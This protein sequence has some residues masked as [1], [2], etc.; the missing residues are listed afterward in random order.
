MGALLDHFY[1]VGVGASVM[2]GLLLTVI[3]VRQKRADK[4]PNRMMAVLVLVLMFSVMLNSFLSSFLP[5]AYPNLLAFP[6]P[7]L[8]L[9]GPLFYYFIQSL[10]GS[11]VFKKTALLH[12]LPFLLVG[13]LFVFSVQNSQPTVGLSFRMGLLI[14]VLWL[15]IYLQFWGYYFLNRKALRGY[16]EKLKQSQSSIEKVRQAWITYCLTTLLICYSILG[17][18]FFL[19]HHEVFLP[20]NKILTVVLALILYSVGYRTFSRPE[21][22]ATLPVIRPEK[23][24]ILV[25][26]LAGEKYQKSGLSE[27]KALTQ[28]ETVE[29]LMK[30]EQSYL[31]PELDLKGLAGRLDFSPHHMS[32]II[33]N[34][35]QRNFYDFVNHYRLEAVKALLRNPDHDHR[36]VLTLAFETG[37]NSKATFN[38]FFKKATRQ[39]P[40]QFR[41]RVR[42]QDR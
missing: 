33:N 31:D 40:S 2:L 28:F 3:V 34:G 37:F 17:I 22:F 20:I 24:E 29:H 16:R 35:S 36:T 23:H 38:R 5:Q 42:G 39:T 4:G 15:V 8:L 11:F 27:Q 21:I 9:I 10:S 41:H 13:V 14:S 1:I 30:Q 32:Q 6:E 7:F 26:E 25:D 19:M 12:G 18:L